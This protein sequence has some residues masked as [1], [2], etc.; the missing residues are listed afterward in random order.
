MKKLSLLLAL[1]ACA[2]W[3]APKWVS[4]FNGKNLDGW[5]VVGDGF[6][7]VLSDGTLVGQRH[8]NKAGH[9]AWLYTKKVFGDFEVEMDFWT[10]L[11]GNSG[12]SILDNSRGRHSQGAEH[13]GSKL[14]SVIGYEIQISFSPVEGRF[15]TGSIYHHVEAK[16]GV[17]KNND[18]NHLNIEHRNGMI[19][20]KLNGQLV[21]ERQRHPEKAKSGPIG[22]QL[23]DVNSILMVRNIRIKEYPAK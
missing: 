22:L 19:R 7:N 6:W 15:P 9:Q 1:C 8:L 5:E 17:R 11:G 18:W 21:A 10:R 20:V 3:A 4:L 14:P 12:V 23:H 2:A 16:R 13:D